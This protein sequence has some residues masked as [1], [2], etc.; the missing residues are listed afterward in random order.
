[1]SKKKVFSFLIFFATIFILTAQDLPIGYRDIKLGMTL[2][3]TKDA[4]LKDSSFGY[5]GER[6]VSLIPGTN[7]VLIETD[8]EYGHGSNFLR[9]CY[10]QFY[11]DSLFV[12][13]INVNPEKMDYYSIFTK[14]CEKYGEPTKLDPQSANWEND[15]YSMRLEKPLTLKYI[16][17][18]TFKMTQNYNNIKA[19]PTEITRE[20]FLDEL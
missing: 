10:F 2:D 15:N 8:A 19:S 6:D 18:E 5:H 13:T 3:E 11:D 17:K 12:I 16:D 14:L 20:M 1:M 9:Q 7:K 4:L